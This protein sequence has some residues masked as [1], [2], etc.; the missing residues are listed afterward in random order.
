[1]TRSIAFKEIEILSN[2]IGRT[3]VPVEA[4]SLL[5]RHDFQEVSNF[6]AKDVPTF[7]QVIVQGLGLILRQNDESVK[8]GI[9]A[10]AQGE[11]Q[12][13]IDPTKWDGWLGPVPGEWHEPFA[14]APSHDEGEYVFHGFTRSGE[15]HDH[16]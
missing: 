10:V 13:S 4:Y 1:M 6:S 7:F 11:I 15:D 2:G 12:Q 5:G 8:L 9:H 16:N 3:P 14:F